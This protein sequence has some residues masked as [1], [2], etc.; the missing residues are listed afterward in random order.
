MHQKQRHRP[1][2]LPMCYVMVAI[3]LTR[4]EVSVQPG[5]TVRAAR[6]LVG[7]SDATATTNIN[8]PIR[9]GEAAGP[10]PE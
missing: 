7:S 3:Q 2:L 8:K 5:D 9:E 6:K 1:R 4:L 10:D